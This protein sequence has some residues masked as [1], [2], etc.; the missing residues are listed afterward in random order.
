MNHLIDENLAQK[1]LKKLA[2]RGGDFF[3]I[4]L[5][6]G[7]ESNLVFDDKH[8][9]EIVSGSDNGIGMRILDQLKT[10]YGFS[11]DLTPKH[12]ED[13]AS[14]LA[15]AVGHE[16]NALTLNFKKLKPH[17]KILI[18]QNPLQ[19]SQQQ[20]IN[21]C[22][23]AS[24]Y[25]WSLDNRISQV[26][27][28]YQESRRSSQIYNSLNESTHQELYLVSL[29]AIITTQLDDQIFSSTAILS[30]A[31]GFELFTESAVRA[32][33]DKAV[34]QSLQNLTAETVC[35]GV[36]PVVISSSAGGT[37]VHE[38]IGHSLEGD[39]ASDNMSLFSH[40]LGQ[41]IANSKL[42][43]I[44]DATLPTN[45]GS[46]E[47]DDEGTPAQR[48]VLIEDGILKTFMTDRLS[49]MKLGTQST[50]NGRR[51]SYEYRPIVRMTNTFIAPGS[52]HPD[53]IIHSVK[54]GLFVKDMGGGQVNT[55]NGDFVFD[56]TEAYL[57]KNG[58]ID[59]P[60]KKA[61]LIG[62]CGEIMQSIERIGSD[63]NFSSGTCGKDDQG[64][65]VSDAIPTLLI[66][67]ITVGGTVQSK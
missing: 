56:C 67:A 36:M 8:V 37:L 16:A 42:T 64:A 11:N 29:V 40:K 21:L 24:D 63:I 65:P 55:V 53:D 38:A 18:H 20:K 12:L 39:L 46:F 3:E 32:L 2:G 57:I 43:I 41:K 10:V 59:K 28:R 66:P 22:Q 17:H 47:F 9:E 31:T 34:R 1:L 48:K 44:D 15:G 30:G 62:N 61:T 23:S 7:F 50:G 6:D 51:Q 14:R 26:E 60:V 52:E 25:A 33:I 4:Y 54:N 49:A 5:E 19:I 45:R 13:L 27:I 58:Q 35:G